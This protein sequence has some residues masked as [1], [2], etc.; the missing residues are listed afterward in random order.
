MKG[1]EL[2]PEDE[3]FHSQVCSG[4]V[5]IPWQN[6]V[7]LSL[8]CV[9]HLSLSLSVSLSSTAS[10]FNGS[11]EGA[12]RVLR[13][14]SRVFRGTLMVFKGMFE[15]LRGK[16]RVLKLVFSVLRGM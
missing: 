8:S 15:V 4:C 6:E 3:T 11:P 13:L 5:S 9:N 7:R 10:G 16:F 14:I 2:Q 1:V 12:Y